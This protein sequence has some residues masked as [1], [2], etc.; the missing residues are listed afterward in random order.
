MSLESDIGEIIR[1]GIWI[2][3]NTGEPGEVLRTD[4]RVYISFSKVY[5]AG[6][7]TDKQISAICKELIPVIYP[8]IMKKLHELH[9]VPLRI[10]NPKRGYKG[11]L[12]FIWESFKS[13]ILKVL[14]NR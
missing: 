9:L 11:C 14:G 2:E 13:L 3:N 7:L 6:V 12:S 5:K 8:I 10:E 1:A 4:E